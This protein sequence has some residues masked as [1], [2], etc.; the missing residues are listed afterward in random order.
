M[1][2]ES[3]VRHRLKPAAPDADPSTGPLYAMILKSFS[4]F[5]AFESERAKAL[6]VGEDLGTVEKKVRKQLAQAGVLSYRL[7]WFE[8][9]SP[10]HFPKQALSAVTTHDLPT[11]AGLWTG[12]DLDA[13]R[14][15][16]LNPNEAGL[17]G[18]RQRLAAM[19]GLSNR[20]PIGKV[21]ERTY[22]LLAQSPSVIVSA[23]L[24]DALGVEKRPNMPATNESWPNWSLPLPKAQEDLERSRLALSIAHALKR[25]GE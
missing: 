25:G 16:G 8:D 23:T 14:K 7:L 21:I 22:R 11:I 13:Q 24:D 12:S 3:G 17:N 9:D 19:T 4:R 2:W 18:I 5:P 15:L 1:L 20:A 10:A 6:I